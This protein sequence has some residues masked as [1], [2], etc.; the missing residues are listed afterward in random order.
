MEKISIISLIYQSTEYAEFLYNNLMKYTPELHN[1]EAEFYFVANDATEEVLN[2]LKERNYPHFI[3]NNKRYTEQ[4]LF[5]MGFAYPEYINRVYA[6]YNYGIRMSE[7]PIIMLINSD[8]CFSPNWLDN[9]R[10]RLT[11]TTAVSSRIIQPCPFRN[12]IN[13][14]LCEIYPFGTTIN[15]FDENAF[16]KKVEEL[17]KDSVS[18]GNLFMPVMLYKYTIELAGY[19]PEGNLHGGRYDVIRKTGDTEFFH[20]LSLMGVEHINSNDSIVYHF[21]CG[22]RLKKV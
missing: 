6:G 14:S 1:G 16:L 10:K 5:N 8:N 7:N 2:F 15:T 20:K 12:P 4:E 11:Y 19:Y 22:E 21:N 3:N 9:L 18:I 13:G 17:R